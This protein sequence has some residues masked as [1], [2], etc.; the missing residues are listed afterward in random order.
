MKQ[1]ELKEVIVHVKQRNDKFNEKLKVLKARLKKFTA[2]RNLKLKLLKVKGV[3][4]T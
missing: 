2:L 3:K 4:I 1:A